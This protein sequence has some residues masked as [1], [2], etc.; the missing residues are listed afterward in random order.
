MG[1]S[2]RFPSKSSHFMLGLVTVFVSMYVYLGNPLWKQL[3]P[4][5]AILLLV[6][7]V[8]AD[9]QPGGWDRF[10]DWFRMP[11]TQE[12]LLFDGAGGVVGAALFVIFSQFIL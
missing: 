7:L 5:V 11:D 3:L 12:D 8:Q 6:E 10:I 2:S 4:A 9:M 1:L